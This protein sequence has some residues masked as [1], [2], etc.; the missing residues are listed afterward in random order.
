MANMG[1]Y[2]PCITKG[3]QQRALHWSGQCKECRKAKGLKPKAR[4]GD[5]DEPVAKMTYK[6]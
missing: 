1:E 2:K 6:R 4:H 5:L 3:C